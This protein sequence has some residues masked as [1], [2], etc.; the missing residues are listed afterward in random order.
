LWE[1]LEVSF[2]NLNARRKSLRIRK[3]N[4]KKEKAK[5]GHLEKWF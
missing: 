3:E 1:G 5:G 2:I 4:E